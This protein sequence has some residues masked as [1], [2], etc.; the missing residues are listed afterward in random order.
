MCRRYGAHNVLDIACATGAQC[1]VLS[2]CGLHATGID[3]SKEMI[4]AALRVD[5]T[6]T[7]L[8]GSAY[9]LPFEN[10]KFDAAV[11]SLAL[12]E[13]T[14]D[15]RLRMIEE[16][17]RVIRESGVLVVA[18]YARPV[19]GRFHLPWQIIRWIERMA[20]PEHHA[21]FVEFVMS[22]CLKGLIDRHAWAPI[23]EACSHFG[24]I[25]IAVVRR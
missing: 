15:E 6:G 10:Q 12:H 13:H 25:G 22:G 18:D 8:V 11:L 24:V 7:Y 19:H 23:D 5:P 20:G 2:A 1:R 4:D 3:L 16:A 9:A 21:G 17:T 14:E